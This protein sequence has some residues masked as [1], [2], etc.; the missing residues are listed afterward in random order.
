MGFINKKTAILSACALGLISGMASV[1]SADILFATSYDGKQVYRVDTFA[2][3]GLGS[4]TVAFN[5]QGGADSLIFRDPNNIIY[6][7]F[8]NGQIRNYNLITNLDTV[9]N[10]SGA[11]GL[12]GPRDI[13]LEPGGNTVLFS[14]DKLGQISRLNLATG[15][16]TPFKTGVIPEG[17]IYDKT[18]ALFAALGPNT[19]NRLDPTNGN[20]LQTIAL[21]AGVQVDGLT[22]DD[23]N[24]FLYV[25][26]GNAN[27]DPNSVSGGPG[28][29]RIPTTLAPGS[30]VPLALGQFRSPD[31]I[32][33][34]GA[35]HIFVATRELTPPP[36]FNIYDFNIAT[37]ISTRNTNVPGLDDL[38]PLVGPGSPGPGPSV[39]L[40]AAVWGGAFLGVLMVGM[41]V[42]Q[43][44]RQAANA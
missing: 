26:N 8:D 2:N 38:A 11:I 19:V 9:L 3:G 1:A 16:V 17:L 44:R 37:G 43:S 35:G 42:R 30:A 21:P 4:S 27:G 7:A 12:Q 5:T 13:V 10:T 32:V 34:N 41:R 36:G 25:S 39:P 31:G 6:T 24:N 15:A 22:Y 28:L 14:D 40:P 29:F 23:A 20:T 33:Y 18:G